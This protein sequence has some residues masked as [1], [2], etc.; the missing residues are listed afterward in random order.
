MGSRTLWNPMS[1]N[2][3]SLRIQ[4]ENSG[5][6]NVGRLYI[7]N[8]VSDRVNSSVTHHRMKIDACWWLQYSGLL[9][10]AI[11]DFKIWTTRGIRFVERRYFK[12]CSANPQVRHS[13]ATVGPVMVAGET[14][15]LK[16]RPPVANGKIPVSDRD[17]RTLIWEILCQRLVGHV[18][19]R[20]REAY[21][22]P[23]KNRYWRR[24]EG[25]VKVSWNETE[26]CRNQWFNT[27]FRD[28]EFWAVFVER[29]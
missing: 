19:R 9:Q 8:S 2:F 10:R 17:Q 23:E 20:R 6:G 14:G 25:E 3:F 12:N 26:I 13:A 27:V 11:K 18:G 24:S 22:G 16:S 4:D 29:T 15:K 5:F 1:W 21:L 7:L 28:L